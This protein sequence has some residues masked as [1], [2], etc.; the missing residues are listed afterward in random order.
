MTNAT[1][2]GIEPAAEPERHMSESIEHAKEGLEHAHHAAEHGGDHSARWIAVLI[3]VLAAALALAEMQEKGAQN[4]YL[5]EH[6]ALSDDWAFY[7][8]KNLRA[9]IRESEASLLA[10]LPN[11]TDPAVQGRI[12]AAHDDEAR[13][14]DDPKGGNGMKQLTAHAKERQE[15]RDHAF[16]DYH[17]FELLVGALQIAIVLAS[18]SV[19]ARA[20]FLTLSAAVIG[21]VAAVAGFAVAFDWI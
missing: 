15:R 11:A 18:V 1:R 6:V 8:A 19:I 9:S 17:H 10:S 16:H 12:K 4:L 14:R 21:A 2:C 13:L 7:Q 20:R 3:A 5:T